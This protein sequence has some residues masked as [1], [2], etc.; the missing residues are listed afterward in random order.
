VLVG[1]YDYSDFAIH[2]FEEERAAR[3]A[4]PSLMAA[5]REI[6]V[7]LKKGNRDTMS[8]E[9]GGLWRPFEPVFGSNSKI[10]RAVITLLRRYVHD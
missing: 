1:E 9:R 2:S 3:P 4:S 6:S 5:A 10:P 8:G 7:Q